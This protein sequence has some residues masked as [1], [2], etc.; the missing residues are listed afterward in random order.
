[1]DRLQDDRFVFVI[2]T[3]EVMPEVNLKIL[4]EERCSDS[5]H[6]P[7]AARERIVAED[8]FELDRAAIDFNVLPHAAV[9]VDH[10]RGQND[11][12][13]MAIRAAI[14]EGLHP[15]TVSLLLLFLND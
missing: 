15:L 6:A 10:P 13:R 14:D 5:E 4:A 12:G 11:H 2:Q 7:L 1:M 9:P 3:G 8:L